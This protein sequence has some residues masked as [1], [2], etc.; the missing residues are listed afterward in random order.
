L[1]RLRD[2]DWTIAEFT[3]V[4]ERRRNGFG[5]LA[6]EAVREHAVSAGASYIEASV[7]R[8][9][10]SVLAFWLACGFR[11]VEEKDMFVTRLDL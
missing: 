9:K 7:H 5:R 10:T 6:I 8:E 4:P 11:I 2:L 1:V 3:V